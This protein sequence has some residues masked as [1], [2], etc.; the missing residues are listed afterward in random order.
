MNNPKHLIVE[1]FKTTVDD[2]ERVFTICAFSDDDSPT[3]N[4]GFSVKHP[5][6]KNH[7][8]HNAVNYAIRR[9]VAW[10]DKKTTRYSD[11]LESSKN[12]APEYIKH[13][14]TIALPTFVHDR[15]D[16]YF[17]GKTYPEWVND[18]IGF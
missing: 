14:Y 18:V 12:P 3:V 16:K 15:C 9:A 10:K 4:I 11:R 6:D 1:H 2:Q 8:K 5:N 17:R 13:L 7:N